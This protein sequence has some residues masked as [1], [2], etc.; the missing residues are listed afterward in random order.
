MYFVY[1]VS[2][3]PV[4]LE[5]S[6][7]FDPMGKIRQKGINNVNIMIWN[8]WYSTL[9]LDECALL[10]VILFVQQKCVLSV[11]SLIKSINYCL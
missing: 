9:K 5:G 8:V 4:S 2:T 7:T 10:W 6:A 3:D 11:T 1:E